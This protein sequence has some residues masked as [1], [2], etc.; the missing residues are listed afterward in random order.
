MEARVLLVN[1]VQNARMSVN[2][3]IVHCLR[4][5]LYIDV[6]GIGVLQDFHEGPHSFPCPPES[7][8]NC[9]HRR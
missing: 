7:Y 9:A 3:Q 4:S 8:M 2:A 5:T 6:E 1:G